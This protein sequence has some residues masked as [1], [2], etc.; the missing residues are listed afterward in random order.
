MASKLYAAFRGLV[1]FASIAFSSAA[2]ASYV[3]ADGVNC[4]ASPSPVG[5]VVAK[6]RKGQSVSVVEGGGGWSRLADPS[7]WVSSTFLSSDTVAQGSRSA[8]SSYNSLRSSSAKAYRRQSS[9]NLYFFNYTAPSKRSKSRK[10]AKSRRS[11]GSGFYSGSGSCPC[12]GGSVCIGP[13]GGRYCITSGG[14]KRYGV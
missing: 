1:V 5:K 7:C 11:R 2:M 4:R 13:R 14:N 10:S 8:P 9:S 3:N 6:L 12:S